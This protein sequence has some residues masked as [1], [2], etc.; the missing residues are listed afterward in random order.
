MAFVAGAAVLGW[1][2]V[3]HLTV[4]T[5]LPLGLVGAGS[6][7]LMRAFF[8]GLLGGPLAFGV[9]LGA[10][11]SYAATFVALSGSAI[12]AA[13]LVALRPPAV[14]TRAR[15]RRAPRNDTTVIT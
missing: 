2:A 14:D 11:G 3:A 6:A 7:A 10:T 5:V 9:V 8:V 4:V 12:A 15:R 1:Q 13:L